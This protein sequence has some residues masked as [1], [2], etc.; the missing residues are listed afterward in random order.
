MKNGIFMHMQ[1]GIMYLYMGKI[2][3]APQTTT[4][5]SFMPPSL[6][7]WPM[8]MSN[9]NQLLKKPLFQRWTLKWMENLSS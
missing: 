2:N 1:M 8:D 6:K 5:F 4:T 9:Y 7:N 3:F